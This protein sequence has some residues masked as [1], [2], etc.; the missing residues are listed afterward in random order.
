MEVIKQR[1]NMMTD[2][3]KKTQSEEQKIKGLRNNE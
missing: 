2:Q 1:V 3:K